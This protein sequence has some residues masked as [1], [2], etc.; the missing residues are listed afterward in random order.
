[1]PLPLSIDNVPTADRSIIGDLVITNTV[2]YFFPHTVRSGKGSLKTTGSLVELLTVFGE[3]A[4]SIVWSWAGFG[5]ACLIP[6]AKFQLQQT[7]NKSRLRKS[8]L[9]KAGDSSL[10]LQMRLDAFIS[11]SAQK[12][13][14]IEELSSSLP[15]P[16]RFSRA[17]VQRMRVSM[18]GKL[19]LD[20]RYDTHE[21]R[22]GL[23][24]SR[25][26]R[27]A[28]WEAGFAI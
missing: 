14:S 26:L 25:L 8:G 16:Q 1:M 24:R 21:F 27:D 7:T 6:L 22:V 2:I 12:H 15:M 3:H 23:R 20:T 18:A 4:A 11:E 9:W 13:R 10:I 5:L 19:K 28:L 17:A